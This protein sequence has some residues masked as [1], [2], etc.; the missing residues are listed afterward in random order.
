MAAYGWKA[1]SKSQ[2]SMVVAELFKLYQEMA[3]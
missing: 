3:K 2:D 1:S